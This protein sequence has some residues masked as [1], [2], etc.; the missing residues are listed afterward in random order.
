EVVRGNGRPATHLKKPRRRASGKCSLGADLDR[1]EGAL[2]TDVED[3]LAVAPPA[4]FRATSA[5][6][7]PLADGIRERRDVDFPVACFVRG[8]RYP[9]PVGGNLTIGLAGLA[10]QKRRFLPAA[11][12]DQDEVGAPGER[13]KRAEDLLVV[14]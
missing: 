4:R 14:K 7:L 11:H 3:L 1:R 10:R 2:G 13:L 8:I 6:D 5:R 9:L 12:V